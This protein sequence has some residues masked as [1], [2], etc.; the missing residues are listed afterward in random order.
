MLPLKQSNHKISWTCHHT[1]RKLLDFIWSSP[2]SLH[3]G[4]R[5]PS[6]LL[7]VYKPSAASPF[8]SVTF[9]CFLYHQLQRWIEIC[10]TKVSSVA[11]SRDS[12]IQYIHDGEANMFQGPGEPQEILLV[13]VWMWSVS[14]PTWG[15]SEA[16]AIMGSM[17][18]SAC[19]AF[20]VMFG[21]LQKRK[22]CCGL[23]EIELC[24]GKEAGDNFFFQNFDH[25]QA[26]VICI[27]W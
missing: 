16:S 18:I 11:C 5:N 23:R 12:V 14:I 24:L 6:T 20:V 25:V 2:K 22:N 9:I 8:L 26:F 13:R 15:V 3:E 21:L 1:L 19:K 17:G 10:A 4:G 27:Q 7:L